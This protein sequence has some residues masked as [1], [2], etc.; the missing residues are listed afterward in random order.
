MAGGV[1]SHHVF[2]GYLFLLPHRDT[3]MVAEMAQGQREHRNESFLWP[4]YSPLD[5]IKC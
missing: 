4:H 5:N 2:G 1:V 3:N